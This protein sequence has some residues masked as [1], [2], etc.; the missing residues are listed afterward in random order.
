L[1]Q[2]LAAV[3]ELLFEFGDVFPEG[4]GFVQIAP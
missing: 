2:V 4:A 3:E 1:V